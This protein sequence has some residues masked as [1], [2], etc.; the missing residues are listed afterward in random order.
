[1][2]ANRKNRDEESLVGNKN[3]DA[4]KSD[5]NLSSEFHQGQKTDRSAPTGRI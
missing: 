1:M 4:Q 3:L 2:M 5:K